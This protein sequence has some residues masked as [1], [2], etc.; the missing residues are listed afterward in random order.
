[1][2]RPVAGVAALLRAAGGLVPQSVAAM[3]P[4]AQGAFGRTQNSSPR[5][6]AAA[7]VRVH[8]APSL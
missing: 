8:D 5:V 2:E 4:A 1:M 6:G 7:P 3:D